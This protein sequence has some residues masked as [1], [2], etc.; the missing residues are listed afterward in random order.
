MYVSELQ[1]V[2]VSCS[3]LQRVAVICSELHFHGAAT[4]GTKTQPSLSLHPMCVSVLQCASVCCS[5][6]QCAVAYC[7]L[8]QYKTKAKCCSTAIRCTPLSAIFPSEY[9]YC[10]VLQCTAA[11]CSIL[12]P[13]KGAEAHVYLLFYPRHASVLQ[14]CSVLQSMEIA[15]AHTSQPSHPKLTRLVHS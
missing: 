13:T 11:C 14:C 15:E 2:A 5:V 7:S 12:Q 10:S 8:Q 6:L 3:D 9:C 1:R 4:E